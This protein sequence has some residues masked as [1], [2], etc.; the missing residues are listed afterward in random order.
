MR[1]ESDEQDR[2]CSKPSQANDCWGVERPS[3]DRNGGERR[4]CGTQVD[5]FTKREITAIDWLDTTASEAFDESKQLSN[6]A[7]VC[8]PVHSKATAW[9]TR[10]AGCAAI[11]SE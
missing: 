10:N 9:S 11:L 3:M 8:H 4:R 5:R 2:K 1:N 6:A 7:V